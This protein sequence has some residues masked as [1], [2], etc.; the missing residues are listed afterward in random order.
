MK[1]ELIPEAFIVNLLF[2]GGTLALMTYGKAEDPF[3]DSG[4]FIQ[5][6]RA[7][8]LYIMDGEY[9]FR[10]SR[11][12]ETTLELGA[13][14]QMREADKQIL[15]RTFDRYLLGLILMAL[16]DMILNTPT[17]M[18]LTSC[19]R[20]ARRRYN[21]PQPAHA[22]DGLVVMR[23]VEMNEEDVLSTETLEQTTVEGMPIIPIH[24]SNGLFL[25]GFFPDG[26]VRYH[27]VHF[28]APITTPVVVQQIQQAVTAAV[29]DPDTRENE[30]ITA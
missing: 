13:G 8:E 10:S 7:S 14:V 16:D 19:V 3:D 1:Q 22:D 17:L 21:H 9:I 2:A 25:L 30:P 27:F 11:F 29:L 23:A 4:Y 5:Q 15:I 18:E 12:G 24:I 28:L 26:S 20:E 6:V